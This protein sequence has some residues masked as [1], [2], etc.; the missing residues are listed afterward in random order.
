MTAA[1]RTIFA[2]AFRRLLSGLADCHAAALAFLMLLTITI[3]AAGQQGEPGFPDIPYV[4]VDTDGN[5]VIA[6]NRMDDRWHPASLTK[7]M[8]AYVTFRAIG[9]GEIS[10]GSPVTITASSLK[11]PPSRMGYPK[12]TRLR[13]DNALRILIVKS[14]NDVALALAQS[15][16]GTT[17]AFVARMNAEAARLGLEN[18]RFVNPHGLHDPG[19]YVSARDLVILSSAIWN[20]FPQFRDLFETPTI[21]AKGQ[22]YTS[23]NLLLERFEGAT[24]MKT[25]FVCASGYNI[26]ASAERDGKRLVAVVLGAASQTQRAEL[27]ARLL[28]KGFKAAGGQPMATLLPP[29][30]PA[31]PVNLRPVLCTEKARQSRYDPASETAVIKSKWLHPRRVTRDPVLVATGGIDGDPSPAWLARAFMP[32]RVP[33]PVKRPAYAVV[34]VDGETLGSDAL[35]RGSIPVPVRRPAGETLQQ[36]VQ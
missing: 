24:G 32:S 26:V 29:Q 16:A 35:L 18:T 23:Y 30:T 10:P 2:F 36:A 1:F 5:Q 7:L 8:T 21:R 33:L 6:A 34:S 25:G 14:A 31:E 12:G 13:F 11:A 4:L 17:A 20:E 3:P 15:L 27:A 22:L 19:Q 28:M 9:R